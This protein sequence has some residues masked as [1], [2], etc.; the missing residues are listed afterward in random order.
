[1][2][3][4][5]LAVLGLLAVAGCS[6]LGSARD[7]DPAELD[8]SWIAVKGV[9]VVLQEAEKDCG[10]AALAMVLTFWGRTTTIGEVLAGCEAGPEGIKARELRDYAARRKVKGFVIP[11]TFEILERELGK[12]H[13]VI[14]GLVKPHVKGAIT[15]YEVVVGLHREKGAVVTLDP[16]HGWRRNSREGFVE[17]WTPAK[18]ITLVFQPLE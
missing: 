16:A 3:F 6:Y 9:P 1:M 15:H 2:R 4:R 7:F 10:A 8:A 14:V 13:P 18:N 5:P 11:G 17:E 12:G